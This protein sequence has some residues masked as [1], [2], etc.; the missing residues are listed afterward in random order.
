MH[1]L[2]GDSLPERGQLRLSLGVGTGDDEAVVAMEDAQVSL[3]IEVVATIDRLGGDEPRERHGPGAGRPDTR[4]QGHAI[5]VVAVLG[6]GLQVPVDEVHETLGES[7][8]Q[9]DRDGVRVERVREELRELPP[10]GSHGKRRVTQ[11]VG[12]QYRLR[13][14]MTS[15]GSPF[16]YVKFV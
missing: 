7:S 16:G 9:F 10:G 4:R 11:A 13:S 1:D 12:F 8:E 3:A 6:D 15:T 2:S 5:R 14:L